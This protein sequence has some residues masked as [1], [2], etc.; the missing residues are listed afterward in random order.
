M[1]APTAASIGGRTYVAPP[2]SARKPSPIAPPT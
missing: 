2:I 1:S